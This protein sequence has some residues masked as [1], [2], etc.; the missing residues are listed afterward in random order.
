MKYIFLFLPLFTA[1]QT[2]VMPELPGY[3]FVTK[4]QILNRIEQAAKY[5]FVKAGGDPEEFE[6]LFNNEK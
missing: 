1:C 4:I 2:A 3:S 6:Q 5:W